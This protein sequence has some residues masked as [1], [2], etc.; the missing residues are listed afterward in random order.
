MIPVRPR[1]EKIAECVY[2]FFIAEDI[3]TFPIDPFSIIKN[4]GWELYRYSQLAEL[5]GKTIQDICDA[6]QTEDACALRDGDTFIIMYNDTIENP[7]RI[8]FTLMHEIGHILLGHLSDFGETQFNRGGLSKSEYETLEREAHGFARNA[9][10]PP[11]I[12]SQLTGKF[13]RYVIDDISLCF[14]IS[15]SASKTRIKTLS[16]DSGHFSKYLSELLVRFQRFTSVILHSK[17][18]KN[19]KTHFINHFSR[20]CPVCGYTK[21]TK[22]REVNDMIYSGVELNSFGRPRIC[23]RCQNEEISENHIYCGVCATYLANRCTHIEYGWNNSIEYACEEPA[24]GNARFCTKC[25]APT[26]YFQAGLLKPW[27]QEMKEKADARHAQ[28]I[29]AFSEIYAE[30]H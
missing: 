3:T 11:F 29:A 6:C 2:H 28:A 23:P 5:H 13:N 8:R 20:H 12:I 27:E 21:F 15:P 9:L 30:P 18:C 1:Y 26:T 4:H 7:N 22:Q 10:A 14:M 16:W 24:A 17:Q 19:C 25:G